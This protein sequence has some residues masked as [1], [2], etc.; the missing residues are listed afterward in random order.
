MAYFPSYSS[1]FD[2]TLSSN[3]LNAIEILRA[4]WQGTL[5]THWNVVKLSP[6]HYALLWQQ[7]ESKEKRL[8]EYIR[9]YM[10]YIINI[11]CYE[12]KTFS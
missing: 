7:L 8:A 1:S 3:I 6:S 10:R 4:R 9:D 2:H 11:F 5:T 12:K